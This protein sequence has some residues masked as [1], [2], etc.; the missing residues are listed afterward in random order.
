MPATDCSRLEDRL[1]GAIWGQFVGD[2]ACLGSHW[3]YDPAEL[4]RRYPQ[5]QGFEAPIAG[6]YHHGKRPGDLTH[7][8]DAALLLLQS[9]ASLGRFD[10]RDFGR[11]FVER[12]GSAEYRGYRDHA[13]RETLARYQARSGDDFD[14]QQGAND[15][16]PATVTRLAPVVVAHL[17]DADWQP[18]V[19]ALTRVCQNHHRASAYA[20]AHAAILRALLKGAE[21]VAACEAV[22]AAFAEGYPMEIEAAD[23]IRRVLAS[24]AE[25]VADAAP[26][27]GLSCPL[28]QSFPAALHAAL[29]HADDFTGAILATLRAGG[30]NAGRAALVG[31][32]IGA[33]Q[34]FRGIPTDWR[35]RL[36]AH[37]EIGTATDLIVRIALDRLAPD[38]T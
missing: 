6:H 15:D 2:A 33:Y 8:G 16:Q 30:D 32:W 29:A 27:F 26:R 37:G 9:V 24:T 1:R 23:H 17:A 35:E 34:G 21:P 5:L 12:M 4:A 31:A 25:P 19:D 38:Q 3:I 36:S 10:P 7:Y 20:R 14:F 22:A 11:R 18:A 28:A 13:S